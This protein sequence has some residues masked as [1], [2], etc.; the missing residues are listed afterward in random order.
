MRR[1]IKAI[2][3]A[4]VFMLTLTVSCSAFEFEVFEMED[5]IER[6]SEWAKDEIDKADEL[7][8]IPESFGLFYTADITRGQF[9]DLVVNMVE[10]AIGKELAA[11]KADTFTDTKELY[12]LKAYE[13]GI[14]N[15]MSETTFQPDA[16]ITREQIA[17]MLYRAILCL[18]KE[19]G[20]T[21]IDKNETLGNYED[22]VQVSD[23]AKAAV[24]VLANNSIMNG[25][26]ETTL[27][28]KMNASMEQ[29]I[30]LVFRLYEKIQ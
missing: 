27:S 24:A 20:K 21:F 8:L 26:S 25:T 19:T 16:L 18:E 1:L 2:S 28:P 3:L 5:I 11:A 4:L 13:S 23:W 15:G 12:I 10:K 17:T 14:V 6:S 29:C 9:A 22:G 30:I 7:G